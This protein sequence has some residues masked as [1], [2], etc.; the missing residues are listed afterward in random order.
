M[1][2]KRLFCVLVCV[3]LIGCSIN[4]K[5]DNKRIYKIDEIPDNAVKRIYE[6][7]F[8][9]EIKF[10]NIIYNAL[11]KNKVIKI[12]IPIFQGYLDDVKYGDFIDFCR[13]KNMLR[14]DAAKSG[15]FISTKKGE[16]K[17]TLLEFIKFYEG[18]ILKGYEKPV[19][20]FGDGDEP[21]RSGWGI[22]YKFKVEN[23][24]CIMRIEV[25]ADE[26]DFARPIG[27]IKS[28]ED[29]NPNENKERSFFIYRFY[30]N[31]EEF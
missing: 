12:K 26:R 1:K 9:Y 24:P 17:K 28:A 31:K 30:I 21:G 23:I 4:S 2:L 14:P 13:T 8:S 6:D 25:S 16:V 27:S 19:R 5:A 20:I 10:S 18:N 11:Y 7:A 29:I 15:L 22:D 3:T